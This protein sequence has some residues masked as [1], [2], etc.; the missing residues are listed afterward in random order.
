MITKNAE[1]NLYQLVY[2]SERYRA[3][4]DQVINDIKLQAESNNQKLNITGA[5]LFNDRY[6][7]QYIEGE[8][9][10]INS[11]YNTICNDPR[12]NNVRLLLRKEIAERDF[13]RW[14]LGVKKLLDTEEN[15]DLLSLLSMLG[16]AK[17]VSESQ[18]DWFK[19][20][21]K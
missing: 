3:D 20:A 7:L 19:L 15:Q 21:L 13:S 10:A 6:F 8:F 18:L 9:N 1:A 5:L 2:I 16:Q 11:L 17:S 14:S 12:H 4:G